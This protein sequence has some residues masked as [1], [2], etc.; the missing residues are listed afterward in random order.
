MN[1]IKPLLS[2]SV[3]HGQQLW[4]DQRRLAAMPFRDS[5]EFAALDC[6][7]GFARDRAVAVLNAWGL[8]EL[9]YPV[10]MIVSELVTNS[11]HATEE[12]K[13]TGMA[14]VVRIWMHGGPLPLGLYVLV[15]DAV[16]ILPQWRD[17]SEVDDMAESGRGL[18]MVVPA[19]SEACG[20]YLAADL[21]GKVTWA[22]ITG[23]G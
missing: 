22:L 18:S 1:G 17:A 19:L 5:I 21:P 23:A 7:P 15:H 14:P 8:G 11:V 20:S 12:V 4:P 9:E 16:V 3:M 2:T 13:W 10:T 6:S